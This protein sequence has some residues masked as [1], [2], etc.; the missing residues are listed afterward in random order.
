M[1]ADIAFFNAYCGNYEDSEDAVLLKT[2]FL[3]AAE[4]I[5]T[6]YFGF[7]PE[8]KEYKKRRPAQER[9]RVPNPGSLE[10]NIRDN[11]KGA[12]QAV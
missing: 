6:D 8:E 10:T 3:K 12:D 9:L 2:E 5:V 11:I 7:S 4:G 1:I